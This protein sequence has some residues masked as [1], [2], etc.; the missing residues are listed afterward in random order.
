MRRSRTVLE[1]HRE[2]RRH[3]DMRST[4]RRRA[5]ACLL[6]MILAGGFAAGC[7]KPATPAS[8]PVYAVTGTVYIPPACPG[9]MRI[10]SPCPDHPLPAATVEAMKGTT[11]V[12]TTRTDV[13]GHY[14]ITLPAG[15][16]QFTATNAGGFRS[17]A[18]KIVDLPPATVVD[19][20]VG[21]GMK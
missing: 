19:L 5:V 4:R 3:T 10:D 8:P 2:L 21:S 13:D 14:R 17:R 16:Y 15:S 6:P 11:V 18:S 20:T 12:A 1:P 7:A 9:P